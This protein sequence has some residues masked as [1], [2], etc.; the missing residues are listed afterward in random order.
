MRSNFDRVCFIPFPNELRSFYKSLQKKNVPYSATVIPIQN[1]DLT[2]GSNLLSDLDENPDMSESKDS[3]LSSHSDE[4]SI[5]SESEEEV[6]TSKTSD[7][8]SDEQKQQQH[9]QVPPLKQGQ[10]KLH[11]PLS[12]QNQKIVWK[13]KKSDETDHIN[14]PFQVDDDTD[15]ENEVLNPNSQVKKI[16]N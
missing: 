9:W 8:N 16:L 15:D 1:P 14:L 2:E 11:N 5:V 13:V 4:K 7:D 6:Y 12:K 3:N 10:A